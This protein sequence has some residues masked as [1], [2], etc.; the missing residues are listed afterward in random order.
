M[1]PD[2]PA[3]DLI[4]QGLDDLAAGRET[5]AALLVSIGAPRLGQLG[6][7]VANPILSGEH[8]LYALLSRTDPDSAH[9]RYNALIRRL[10]S[11][12]RALACAR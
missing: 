4:E 3:H 11:F 9:S 12:E 2:L 10:V 6:V 7:S 1:R 5:A 8:R